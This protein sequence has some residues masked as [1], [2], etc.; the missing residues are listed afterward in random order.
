MY[1]ILP[2]R[3]RNGTGK[4]IWQIAYVNICGKESEDERIYI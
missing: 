3:G 1:D 2:N 4:S